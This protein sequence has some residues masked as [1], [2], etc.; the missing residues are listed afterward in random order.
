MLGIVFAFFDLRD[1]Y[2]SVKYF[3][4]QATLDFSLAYT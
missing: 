3:A 2:S 1:R 4:H